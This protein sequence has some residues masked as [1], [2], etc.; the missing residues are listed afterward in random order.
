LIGQTPR[1]VAWDVSTGQEVRRFFKVPL[2]S[3]PHRY[4]NAPLSPDESLLADADREG[5]IRLRE[6]MTGREVRALKGH[7]KWVG[8]AIFSPDGQR[9][10]STGGDDTLRVWDVAKG[11]QLH[12]FNGGGARTR[13]LAFSPD[14]R[15]LASGI[16]T[17]GRSRGEIILWDLTNGGE[18]MR[19]AFMGSKLVYQIAF[20]PDSRLLVAAGGLAENSPGEIK[21]WEAATGKEWRSLDGQKTTILSVAFS[22][23]GRMLAIGDIDGALDLWELASG[24]KRYHFI[25]HESGIV[26][27]LFAG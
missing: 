14:N 9:L 3:V 20:S 18:K 7:E 16:D 24:R 26:S 11:R 2:L 12:K 8:Y 10:A 1:Y 15:W 25:G 13:S 19:F 27:R 17:P 5:T 21:V 22:T 6:A 4:F 23:D